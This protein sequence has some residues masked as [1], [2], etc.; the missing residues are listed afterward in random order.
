MKI[1]AIFDFCETLV[2]LQ[3]IPPFLDKAQAINPH[4][5]GRFKA[6]KRRFFSRIYKR[7]R[8]K[9]FDY[10]KATFE[11]LRGLEEREAEALAKEYAEFLLTHLNPK[12]IARLQYHKEQNHT[13]AIVSG[14]LEIYIKYVADF[15]LIPR[16][17]IVAISLHSHNGI[18]SGNIEG[19]H[20]MEHRKL[21]KL[22]DTLDLSEFD[23]QKSY[24]YSDC[25]SDI[26]LLSFVGNPV[27]VEC[28]K[29]LHWAEILGYEIL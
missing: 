29:E 9:I 27:V 21:Y 7:I 12:V 6:I 26:P 3:S 15:L 23:L 20:T 17:N 16:E 10:Q 18:L 11:A 28:G 8:L 14:G 24:F 2:D 22:A 4:Y 1:L 5:Q 19:I 13:L 25:A